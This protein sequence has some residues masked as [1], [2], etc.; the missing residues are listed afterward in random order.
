MTKVRT[1]VRHVDKG[2]PLGSFAN[3][4]IAVCPKCLGPALVTCKSRYAIPFIPLGSR[5]CCLKC[6][7]E[8]SGGELSWLGPAK[9]VAKERCPNCGFKWLEGKYT[10]KSLGCGARG[11]AGITCPQCQKSSRVQIVW[12]AE[13]LGKPADPAFG[14]P[15]WLQSPCCD[16][17]LWA[18]NG[19]H[20]RALRDYV[21]SDLRER[22]G[23]LYWST[24]ARLPK[25]VSAGKNRDA[26][27]RCIDRLGKK[28]ATLQN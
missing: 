28:L 2:V 8:K 15:L 17:T 11:Q 9:G 22:T 23:V 26:V 27:L 13:R 10:C 25:W 18:Y 3:E 24:F 14:L 16:E 21:A 6:S 12:R 4:A 19:P 1:Q 5:V 7:F 20:L